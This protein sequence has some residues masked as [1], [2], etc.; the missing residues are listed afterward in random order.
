M[1]KSKLTLIAAI[2]LLLIAIVLLLPFKDGGSPSEA[3]RNAV[4]EQIPPAID[5]LAQ[6]HP[7]QVGLFRAALNQSG[8]FDALAKVIVAAIIDHANQQQSP[9]L[10]TSYETYYAVLLD[11]S[12]VQNK[13]A[14]T[15]EQQFGMSR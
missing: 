10:L 9:G 12:A 1:P 3:A 11:K 7:L 8:Q 14:D 2:A 4:L 13:I 5:I 15:I 6:R